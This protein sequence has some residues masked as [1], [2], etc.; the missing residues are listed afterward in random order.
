MSFLK[1][2]PIRFGPILLNF[3]VSPQPNNVD[4]I[5]WILSKWNNVSLSLFFAKFCT[6][7]WKIWS[8]EIVYFFR[9][10]HLI[11]VKL[12]LISKLCFYKIGIKIIFLFKMEKKKLY[13]MDG[14]LPIKIVL[15]LILK[16]SLVGSSLLGHTSVLQAEALSL[17]QAV[18]W[19]S[20]QILTCLGKFCS[21]P[22]KIDISRRIL[23][24][25]TKR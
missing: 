18:I 23:F 16:P 25:L 11:L 2:T 4:I 19:L 13:L 12:F 8:N 22:T 10:E 3:G 6:I 9:I 24:F 17:K 5:E 21:L 14:V 15:K 1:L 7:C 20:R